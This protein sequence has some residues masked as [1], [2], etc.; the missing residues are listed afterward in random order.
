MVSVNGKKRNCK[1]NGLNLYSD[2]MFEEAGQGRLTIELP[3][4]NTRDD[5]RKYWRQGLVRGLI[6]IAS[7]IRGLRNDNRK[8]WCPRLVRIVR[9]G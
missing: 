7:S 1:G 5:S 4:C 8:D 6:T 2:R 3:L 9:T